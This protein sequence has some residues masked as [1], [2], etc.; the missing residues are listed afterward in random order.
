VMIISNELH[1]KP[2]LIHRQR[3]NIT[4]RSI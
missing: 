2:K 1:F 4:R 3:H